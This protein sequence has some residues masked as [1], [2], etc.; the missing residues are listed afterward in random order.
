MRDFFTSFKPAAI[1][2]VLLTLLLGIVYP[3]LLC[4]VGQLFFHRKANGS[5]IVSAEKKVVGSEWIAQSFTQ[6][7]YF[8]PRPSSAGDQGFDATHSSGSNLGPTS[9]KLIDAL[10]QRAHDY[11]QENQL[12]PDFLLPADAITAS[13]SGLDPHISLANALLQAPRVARARN[14]K[15]EEVRSLVAQYTE[16]PTLGI[17]GEA[18]VHVLRLN[19]ALDSL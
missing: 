10:R 8:H 12:S 6:P 16:R 14:L 1:A 13:G 17:L 18:R 2:S 5:L 15:E 7:Q 4:G 3:L 11:R 9:Q 19:L